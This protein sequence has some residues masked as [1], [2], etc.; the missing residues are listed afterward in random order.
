MSG[1][2]RQRAILARA[3]VQEAPLVL[4]DEPTSHLDIAHQID[5]LTRVRE[6]SASEG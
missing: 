5:L 2:E 1:G 6:L 3:L 4:L